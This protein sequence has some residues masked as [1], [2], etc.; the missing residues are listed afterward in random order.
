MYC[1]SSSR[2]GEVHL[3]SYRHDVCLACASDAMP[4]SLLVR[5][6][7]RVSSARRLDPTNSYSNSIG[8]DQ[9]A[10]QQPTA[11]GGGSDDAAD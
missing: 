1:P 5:R 10:N 7:P 6:G 9:Q 3:V 4:P 11:T 8:F 2:L